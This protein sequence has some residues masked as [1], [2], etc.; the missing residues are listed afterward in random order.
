[1]EE[2]KIDKIIRSKRRTIAL[3][4]SA[5]ATLIVR[6]PMRTAL[7]YI[8]NLVF[9]K[10][11][12]ISKKKKQVLENGHLVK[13]KEFINGEE[14]LYL[15][16]KYKLKIENCP[17]IKLTDYL[18]FPEKYLNQSRIKMVLWYKHN[19]LEKL[20]ERALWYSQTTGWKFKSISI[21]NAKRQWGSCGPSGSL[22]F[23]WR[24]IMAPLEVIDYVVVHELAHLMERNHS[25]RFWNNVETVLP[26]Y[27]SRQN[28][29]KV[30]GINFII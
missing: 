5:D 3:V 6:A 11:F 27:K 12:W 26:D 2:V 29:L 24:L 23:T 22:N 18:Y 19:A 13:P 14:F 1:M 20:T 4:V 9:K 8:E 16:K 30:N 25:S 21:T 10:R 17:D 7:E 28:C 15:G